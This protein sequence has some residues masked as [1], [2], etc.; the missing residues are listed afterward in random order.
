VVAAQWRDSGGPAA[1]TG[2]VDTSGVSGQDRPADG[3][4]PAQ[5]ASPELVRTARGGCPPDGRDFRAGQPLAAA[6]AESAR[7]VRDG[8]DDAR[9]EAPWRRRRQPVMSGGGRGRERPA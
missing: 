4:I 3:Q 2:S 7:R 9:G 1:W 8:L 5:V 6:D